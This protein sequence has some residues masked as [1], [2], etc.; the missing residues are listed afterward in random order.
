MHFTGYTAFRRSPL[1]IERPASS[2]IHRPSGPSC[3]SSLDKGMAA[4]KSGET[5]IIIIAAVGSVGYIIFLLLIFKCCRRSESTPLPPIQPLAYHRGRYF[6]NFPYPYIPHRNADLGHASCHWSDAPSLKPSR[7]PSLWTD[8]SS[9]T[10]PSSDRSFFIL[11]SP[12]TNVTYRPYSS[13]AESYSDETFSITHQYMPTIR[14]ARSVSRTRSWR[15]LSRT[16]STVSTCTTSTRVLMRSA[17]AID[18]APHS[19]HSTILIMPTPLAPRL[20]SHL[21]A[22]LSAFES[23]EVSSMTERGGVADRWM[24]APCRTTSKRS[25]SDQDLSV[26]GASRGETTSM[27]SG[28]RDYRFPDTMD[29]PRRSK[30]Q[31]ES[32]VRTSSYR[33][34]QSHPPGQGDATP[35]PWF[36]GDQTRLPG[37]ISWKACDRQG[38]LTTRSLR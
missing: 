2:L 5:A 27:D 19:A 26:Q 20:Q 30:L 7:T 25:N 36:L 38:T 4:L 33:S 11:P 12:P 35:S 8:K 22:N 1:L 14:Q 34:I 17:N 15:Q 6:K 10:P 24:T 21:I 37:A 31:K 3:P 32:R 18:G 28:Y 9:G 16:N 29:R 23:Y 13:S